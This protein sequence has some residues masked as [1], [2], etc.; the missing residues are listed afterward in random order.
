MELN[1]KSVINHLAFDQNSVR[2]LLNEKNKEYFSLKFPLF[3]K[4]GNNQSAIDIAL[5]NNLNFSVQAIVDYI[6]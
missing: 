6:I 3:Y 5:Q 1:L 4:D 2:E